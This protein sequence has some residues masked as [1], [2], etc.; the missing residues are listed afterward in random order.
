MSITSL[1]IHQTLLL[2]LAPTGSPTN[3]MMLKYLA[4]KPTDSSMCT[5]FCVLRGYFTFSHVGATNDSHGFSCNVSSKMLVLIENH[6]K[7]NLLPWRQASTHQNIDTQTH[8][9]ETLQKVTKRLKEKKIVE[10]PWSCREYGDS[11]WDL[12]RINS[13]TSARHEDGLGFINSKTTHHWLKIQ[14]VDNML[15]QI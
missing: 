1:K 13:P 15:L 10:S 4:N 12:C 6:H 7:H 9:H 3:R 11:C 2:P 5:N 8:R 14:H